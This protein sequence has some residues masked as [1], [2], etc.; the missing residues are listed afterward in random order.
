MYV[1]FMFV[2]SNNT[3]KFS[4]KYTFMEIKIRIYFV[5]QPVTGVG[6]QYCDRIK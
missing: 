3:P 5:M 2:S 6:F 4:N 1:Y